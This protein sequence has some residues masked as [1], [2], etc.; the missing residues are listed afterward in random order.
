MTVPAPDKLPRDKLP[1][2]RLLSPR[3]IAVVGASE[4][5]EAIGTRVIR[6]LRL[7]GFPGAI[8]PVNPRY[9]TLGDLTCY[10]SLAALPETVDAAFFGIPAAGGPEMLAQA[11]DAGVRAVF[12]NANGYADGDATGQAL[13]RE[14][15]RIARQHNIAVAG[16]NNLGLVN[17]L[18]RKAMWTVRYFSPIAPGPIAVISQSGSIALILSEDERKLGFA[19]LVTTGNE[20]VVTV[21]DYLQH[22]AS[23]DR[24]GVIL[25]FLETVRDP[26]LFAR[27]ARTALASGKRIIALKLGRSETGRALVQAHTGSLAGEDRLYDAY[28]RALGILAVRDLDEMMETA[29]LLAAS[30]A[31]PPTRHFVP[32]TLSGGEAA[33]MADIG[34]DLG[35]DY[36]T[37]ALETLA[38]LRPAFPPYSSIGNPLDAWGLGFNPDRFGIVLQALLDD[39]QIGTIG[40]SIDAPGQGGGDVPYACT[41]AEACVAASTDKRLVFFNNLVGTGVNAEVR[42]ILD[43]GRIPYLCG[44]RAALAAI[45][46]LIDTTTSAP[47]PIEVRPEA[48]LPEEETA[49]FAALRAAGVPMVAAA[50]VRSAAEAIAAAERIGFPVAMKGIAAHLPHKSDL[51]LVRLRLLDVA[52][53]TAAY[54][55]LHT[56][57]RA[58]ATDGATGTVEV[59]AMAPDGVELIVGI[60]NLPG[61][62]SFVLV[63][64][65]GVLVEISKQASVRLGPVDVATARAMLAETAAVTLLAGVRGRPRCDIDAAAEAIAAFSRVGAAHAARYAALEINPLIV[66]PRGALGVDLLIEPA[67]TTA[68][69]ET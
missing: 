36:A 48:A 26:A 49:R 17:V 6:N 31:P 42:A 24:V 50:L 52:G 10:P 32:L 46:H 11:A 3:S 28:F 57:L 20:A 18:D 63:G 59:Q 68:E 34:A 2:D 27:A 30:R 61:S 7:M 67:R 54:H 58:H 38:R 21:A 60:N 53:V 65:G 62:G 51:G 12:I 47:P 16:P 64:P 69:T 39:P 66:G 40:F 5:P 15:T 55:E 45:A 37:L 1:L 41:M 29:V 9:A 14:L 25:L 13:Q 23:D 43:R 8:Y 44:M 33:L 56:I 4:R 35:I 19:Y 22:V